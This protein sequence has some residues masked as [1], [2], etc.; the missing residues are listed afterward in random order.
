[1][2]ETNVQKVEPK[3]EE[4]IEKPKGPSIFSR[5]KNKIANFKRVVEVAR[6]PDKAEFFSS[7]KITGSGIV[8]IGIIG[9]IIFLIYFLVVK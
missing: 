1:M 8:L 3:K 5:L 2:E 4:K 6:K 9:F 7:L